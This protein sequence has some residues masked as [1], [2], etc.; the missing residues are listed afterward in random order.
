M[1]EEAK[2]VTRENQYG[3]P[4]EVPVGEDG[5]NPVSPNNPA[6][7]QRTDRQASA[8]EVQPESTDSVEAPDTQSTDAGVPQ[9]ET[10]TWTEPTSFSTPPTDDNGPQDDVAQDDDAATDLNVSG[11]LEEQDPNA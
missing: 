9:E 2:T 6:P 11:D 3:D 4:I 10:G 8:D 5:V 7:K 1:T